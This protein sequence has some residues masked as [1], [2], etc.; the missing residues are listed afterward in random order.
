MNKISKVL[1]ISI[2]FFSVAFSNAQNPI[3]N[4]LQKLPKTSHYVDLTEAAEHSIQAVVHIKTEFKQKN[5]AWDSYFSGSFWEEFFGMVPYSHSNDYP[6]QAAGSGVII[7]SDG[8]I[9]T[10]NH[11]VEDAEKITV[12][13]NDK[14]EFNAT[15]VGTDAEA[16]LALIK[17]EETNLPF[18]TFGNSD[19]VRIG[20]WV[21]AVGNPF[22][23]TSTVTAG[24]VSA[25]ARNLN[26]MD[27]SSNIE[28]FIQTDAALNQGNSG[29]ALV[30]VQGELIGINTAIA[31]GTGYYTGYSF[32]IPSNI[33]RKV[34]NDLKTYGVVQR[35]Y[36]G[37]SIM[38]IT[39]QKAE[40]LNLKSLEGVVVSLVDENGAA[41]Q[42]GMQ[43][44]D[45]ILAINDI[46]TNS[47]SELREVLMQHSPGETVSVRVL[48]K[49]EVFDRN[50]RLLNRK[51]TSD[52]IEQSNTT[53]TS[54]LGA[55]FS[56][57]SKRELNY[58]RITGG[59]KVTNLGDGLLRQSGVKKGFVITMINGR[60][61]SDTKDLEKFIQNNRDQYLAIEGVYDNGYYK[62]T[63]TIQIP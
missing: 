5:S 22:N 21:L 33:A 38:D 55:S 49:G 19:Q 26:I 61:I 51:G 7:A 56:D 23:L 32:A 13:L 10:N 12:T 18:L 46:K 57:L 37:V 2:L 54:V 14:R 11:V 24:I 8:Y 9:I 62:Y 39:P 40:E 20:E 31:S 29:G 17:I 6:V 34:A 50:V 45:V 47:A 48:H 63:Y 44:G 27:G 3:E 59:V 30:N 4:N 36:L 25:K 60:I 28:S 43:E 16:D 1:V 35:A 41:H 15:L 53:A 58:Y 52:I 42:G